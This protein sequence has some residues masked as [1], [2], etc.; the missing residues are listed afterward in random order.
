M[1]ILFLCGSLEPGRDGVGDYTRRLAAE[2]IRQGHEA[3]I[4]ALCDR[5]D[6]NF[7]DSVFEAETTQCDESTCV[8]CTRWSAGRDWAWKSERLVEI[9]RRDCPDVVSIQFVPYAFNARGLPFP[10]LRCVARCRE[11]KGIHW[12]IMFHELW[13]G[14]QKRKPL[15]SRI[16]A[17]LQRA[18][19]GRLKF[20][21]SI[22]THLPV[23]KES[24][25]RIGIAAKPLPLFSNIACTAPVAESKAIGRVVNIG[26]FS[27]QEP[28]TEVRD[29]II[30]FV[31][32]A[33]KQG[34][35]VCLHLAGKLESA[36]ENYWRE[37][38]AD[39]A[40]IV[41]HGW[42]TPE[43]ISIYLRSL[44]LGV[45][46]VPRHAIGKSGSVAAFFE[47]GIPVAA[48]FVAHS[49]TGLFIESEREMVLDHFGDLT[50]H[51][52]RP[53]QK[54]EKLVSVCTDFLDSLDASSSRSVSEQV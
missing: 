10:F 16:I 5:E 18:M 17:R 21:D 51:R 24:L 37:N 13:I 39:N 54:T 38:L 29:W 25:A 22:H 1:K 42:M 28:V 33:E 40:S 20:C 11:V 6:S 45:T 31:R 23:Y 26:F 30:A 34:C 2:C 47:H 48:P 3:R 52:W 7:S 44:D 27:Q 32:D 53:E 46:T 9:L 4:L 35:S 41:V 8:R 49:P 43:E 14:P 19:I 15:S 36:T 50:R 12:H